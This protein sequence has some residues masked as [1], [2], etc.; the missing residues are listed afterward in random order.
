VK[1]RSGKP[2]GAEGYRGMVTTG[3]GRARGFETG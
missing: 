1:K 3:P 2:A